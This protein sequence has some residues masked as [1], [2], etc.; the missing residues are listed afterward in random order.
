LSCTGILVILVQVATC[1]AMTFYY[2][3]TVM[4]AFASTQYIITE[5]NFG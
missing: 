4:E 1:F 5:A 3:L 2:R